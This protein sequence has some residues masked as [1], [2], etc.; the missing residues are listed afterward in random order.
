MIKFQFFRFLVAIFAL[1]F[2]TSCKKDS[3]K[4]DLSPKAKDAKEQSLKDSS[5]DSLIRDD[6]TSDIEL[7]SET[8]TDEI[9][10]SKSETDETDSQSENN[11]QESNIKIYDVAEQVPEFPGGLQAI[12]KYISERTNEIKE[13]LD[14]DKPLRTMVSFIVELDGTVSNPSVVKS[15]GNNIFD[16]EAIKIVQSMP[17]WTPAKNDG[18]IVRMKYMLPVTYNPAH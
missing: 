12:N 18:E 4:S 6:K 8:D 10:N 13:Q 9:N 14:T 11:A 5:T 17:A 16:N 1:C 2:I 7:N 3:P 15:S